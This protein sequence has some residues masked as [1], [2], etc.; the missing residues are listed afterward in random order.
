[1]GFWE[2][3]LDMMT[4]GVRRRRRTGT[5][6]RLSDGDQVRLR[7]GID[8]EQATPVQRMVIEVLRREGTMPISVLVRRVAREIYADE[9][10]RGAATID[11][12]I[13]G[14]EL[15]AGDVVLELTAGGGTLWDF[16]SGGAEPGAGYYPVVLA[17]TARAVVVIGGG[18]TAERRVED[19][20][21]VGASVS[22]VNPDLSPRLAAWAAAGR[23]SHVERSYRSGDLRGYDLA[24]V[25]MKN[26]VM[27]GAVA[28]EGRRRGVWVNAADDP[29]HCDFILPAVLRRADLL[30]AV[31]TGGSSPA[32]SRVIREELDAY[33]TEDY[34]TLAQLAAEARRDLRERSCPA[35][36]DTWHAALQSELLRALIA[37]G[38]RDEA[39]QHLLERLGAA[40][41]H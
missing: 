28:E 33:L 2:R 16:D 11:I 13:F 5:C 37:R 20:L 26:A 8:P 15:F 29:V 32:L 14:S 41:C 3:A 21:R 24:F 27:A 23:I 4:R 22:V 7:P 39:K 1:M 19:L 31:A 10:R 36:A 38:K 34:A 9:L 12:G 18:P 17:M 30:V 40:P 25:A 35:D 6:D